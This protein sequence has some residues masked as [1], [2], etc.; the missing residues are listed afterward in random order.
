MSNEINFNKINTNYQKKAEPET[1]RTLN[2]QQLSFEAVIS[3]KLNQKSELQLSK[4]A[5]QRVSQHGI[6]MNKTLIESIQSA[7]DTAKQKG[8][9]DVVIIGKDAA[10]VVNLTNGII[11]TAVSSA[12]MKNNIFTNIDSAVLI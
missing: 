5:K 4:H 6:D 2:H 3:E 9:K 11:V 10:F 8:A 1:F 12:D 7:A